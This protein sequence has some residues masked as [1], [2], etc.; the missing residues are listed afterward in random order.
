MKKIKN[1]AAFKE[2]IEAAKAQNHPQENVEEE[3]I[4]EKTPAEE[5]NKET[6]L[7]ITEHETGE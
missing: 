5:E 7:T 2:E 3:V 4:V 1:D 6:V